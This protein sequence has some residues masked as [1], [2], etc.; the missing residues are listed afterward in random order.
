MILR[1]ACQSHGGE[2]RQEFRSYDWDCLAFSRCRTAQQ[3][4]AMIGM[5]AADIQVH[6]VQP[7]SMNC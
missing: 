3:V 1:Q 4:A 7:F 5:M 6:C 2:L